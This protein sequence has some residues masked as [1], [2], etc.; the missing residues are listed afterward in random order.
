MAFRELYVKKP[1]T[2]STG[3]TLQYDG[4]TDSF[5]A[6]TGGQGTPGDSAYQVAVSNGF[7]GTET[8]WLTSLVGAQ[9]SAGADGSQGPQGIQGIQGVQGPAGADGV[10]VPIGSILLIL[11]G[12]CPSGFVEETGLDG[13]FVR[14]TIA[15]NGDIGTTAGQDTVTSVL[16]HTHPVNVTDG[17][18]SH[19]L[20]RYPTTTGGSSGFTADTSM[21]GTLTA[22]TL[23]T[24]SATT[25][26]S[27]TTSNPAGGVA[28]T[29][30]RPSFKRVI[31]CRK[32]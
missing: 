3:Q 26:I 30:N 16:N 24:A 5:V 18:H 11:S 7:V 22:V 1:E 15:A 29:D 8:Q 25:G 28:S 23:P 2:V 13:F 21:S 17:G 6:A 27:A 19:G 14:G 9:G 4:N 10:G 31:F 20:V 32:T 12:T